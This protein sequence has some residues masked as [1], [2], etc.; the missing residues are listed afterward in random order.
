M[1]TKC[2]SFKDFFSLTTISR[3]FCLSN[4]CKG[5]FSLTTI[6]RNF[7]HSIPQRPSNR[8]I[9]DSNAL[10]HPIFLSNCVKSH[11]NLRNF[12]SIFFFFSSNCYFSLVVDV[13]RLLKL[14]FPSS[15]LFHF[16]HISKSISRN[17]SPN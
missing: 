14:F 17:I 16:L 3:N 8:Q 7:S 6:S 10:Q 4:S 9:V 12:H 11:S 2:S 1:P 15:K 5:S 13:G